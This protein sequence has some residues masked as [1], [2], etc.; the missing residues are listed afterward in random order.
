MADL[1]V[2][3]DDLGSYLCAAARRGF[4][5]GDGVDCCTLMADWLM[6]HGREDVMADRRGTYR[7]GA[8]FRRMLMR[9]GGLIAAC[10]RRFTRA[11]L[12][13][14]TTPRAGDVATVMLPF[15]RRE[16]RLMYVATGAIALSERSFAFIHRHMIVATSTVPVAK[17][18]T[19]A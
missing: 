9:E 19:F 14:T 15:A 17:V 3:G 4:A 8:D 13:V 18:W 2:S 6:L 5:L 1:F 10:H 11:G 16:G 7:T 12:A